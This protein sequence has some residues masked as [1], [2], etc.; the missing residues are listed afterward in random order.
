M[1][2][3]LLKL[4][5]DYYLLNAI[6]TKSG[7]LFRNSF[8]A[9]PLLELFI[10]AYEINSLHTANAT[11]SVM[12]R[13]R[14]ELNFSVHYVMRK[15]GNAFISND[16]YVGLREA[17]LEVCMHRA[18]VSSFGAQWCRTRQILDCFGPQSLDPAFCAQIW[19]LC[20]G[21]Y[22][23]NERNVS[24]CLSA[25]NR[26]ILEQEAAATNTIAGVPTIVIGNKYVIAGAVNEFKLLADVCDIYSSRLRGCVITS[27]G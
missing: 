3:S 19:T 4:D 23:L 7:V 8:S 13:F 12:Q 26:S 9:T 1:K 21:S 24:V 22:S 10:S 2:Q 15:D 11:Y 20:A 14:N 17:V 18:N 6:E 5:D 27:R 16:G 25:Q